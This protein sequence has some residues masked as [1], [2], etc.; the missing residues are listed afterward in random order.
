MEISLSSP[1]TLYQVLR[2]FWYFPEDRLST[3][4]DNATPLEP[5]QSS[6]ESTATAACTGLV[7]RPPAPSLQWRIFILP[8]SSLQERIS[9]CQGL[10]AS[11]FFR[12]WGWE[13]SKQLPCFPFKQWPKLPTFCSHH[14]NPALQWEE[15]SP[16][17]WGTQIQFTPPP[18]RRQTHFFRAH[19][20][21]QAPQ[22]DL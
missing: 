8:A 13:K 5:R 18:G 2:W 22:G 19:S 14:L 16:R 20:Y 3:Y 21:Y 7:C 12:R 9:L 4:M 10:R 17:T 11:S 1:S 6:P 15:H